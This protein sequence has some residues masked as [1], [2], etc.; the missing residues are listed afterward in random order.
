V[1]HWRAARCGGD[2]DVDWVPKP[3]WVQLQRNSSQIANFCTGAGVRERP[4][5]AFAAGGLDRDVAVALVLRPPAARRSHGQDRER[6]EGQDQALLEPT[7]V[8]FELGCVVGRRSASVQRPGD[9][10]D[11]ERREA[12]DGESDQGQDPGED[13]EPIGLSGRPPCRT[14]KAR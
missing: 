10:R 5:P 13:L 7:A 9:E 8:A 12:G 4:A 11:E 6:D 2:S 1:I 14:R 3:I